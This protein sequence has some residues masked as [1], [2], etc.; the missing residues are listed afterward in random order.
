MLEK[1]KEKEIENL[2]IYK[3]KDKQYWKKQMKAGKLTR[4][5]IGK[6]RQKGLL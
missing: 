3:D 4:V 6:L 2:E 1:E 5:Q